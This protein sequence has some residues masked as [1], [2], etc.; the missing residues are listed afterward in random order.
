MPS[1]ITETVVWV[2]PAGI[3]AA[4]RR[5]RLAKTVEPSFTTMWTGT[6]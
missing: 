2:W 4:T 3:A 5:V 6:S 1:S